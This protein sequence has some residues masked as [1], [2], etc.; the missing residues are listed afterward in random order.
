MDEER[1]LFEKGVPSGLPPSTRQANFAE[2][3]A[4]ISLKRIADSLEKMLENKAS[5]VP[6]H[7]VGADVDPKGPQTTDDI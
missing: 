3:S 6:L 1:S 4:A 7:D 2:M 5:A